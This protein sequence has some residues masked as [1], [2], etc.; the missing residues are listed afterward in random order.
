MKI[1]NIFFLFNLC[2][3]L[4]FGNQRLN[5]LDKNHVKNYVDSWVNIWREKP[6]PLSDLRINEAW[7][8]VIL[9]SQNKYKDNFYCLIFN[10]NNYFILLSED[11]K[12][13]C[14]QVIGLLESPDNNYYSNQIEELHNELLSLSNTYNYTLD[15]S[16][17]KNWS[18]GFYFYNYQ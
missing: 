7:K 2:S 11:E 4:I 6:Y 8:S 3:S 16:L 9:C 5:I 15:Y 1:L 14:L 18:H 17:M 12:K 13:K 10:Q